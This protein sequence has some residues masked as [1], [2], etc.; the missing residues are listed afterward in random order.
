VLCSLAHL[1]ALKI[2]LLLERSALIDFFD[3]RNQVFVDNF[4]DFVVVMSSLLKA[5]LRLSL[6]KVSELDRVAV[7]HVG[8]KCELALHFKEDFVDLHELGAEIW[9]ELDKLTAKIKA[10][11]VVSSESNV[12][13]PEAEHLANQVMFEELHTRKHV[14]HRALAHPF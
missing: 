9:P 8:R 3:Q 2:F 13:L 1:S 11:S 12:A 10:R 4:L 5:V 14:E 7:A 6:H